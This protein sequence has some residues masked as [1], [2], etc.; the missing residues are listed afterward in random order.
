MIDMMSMKLECDRNNNTCSNLCNYYNYCRLNNI[1]SIAY[2]E[3]ENT[4]GKTVA[5]KLTEDPIQKQ[6][7]TVISIIS[8]EIAERGK[9]LEPERLI[10]LAKANIKLNEVLNE[11]YN[12]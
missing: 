8:N 2:A 4:E 12:R 10:S 7:N 3:G 5:E 1:G 11:L 9:Q 6:I